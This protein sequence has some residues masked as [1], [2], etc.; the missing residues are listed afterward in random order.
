[1]D[2]MRNLKN[3]SKVEACELVLCVKRKKPAEWH[4]ERVDSHKVMQAGVKLYDDQVEDRNLCARGTQ[5][6]EMSHSYF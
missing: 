5:K 1:M 4:F 6:C 3:I 2:W